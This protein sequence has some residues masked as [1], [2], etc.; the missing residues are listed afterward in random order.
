MLPAMK[1]PPAPYRIS[2]EFGV[3]SRLADFDNPVKPATDVLQKKYGFNDRDVHEAVIKKILVAKGSEYIGF[4]I[5][6]LGLNLN[7]HPFKQQEL[8]LKK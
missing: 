1:L 3:S 4:Q 2:F 8:P 7:D 5:E 6:S